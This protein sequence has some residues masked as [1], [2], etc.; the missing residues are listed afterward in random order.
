MGGE[1]VRKSSFCGT[2]W[3]GHTTS[4]PVESPGHRQKSPFLDLFLGVSQPRGCCLQSL[5]DR[6]GLWELQEVSAELSGLGSLSEAVMAAVRR[7]P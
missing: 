5:T 7:E 4:L 3:V 2:C 6:L 1:L